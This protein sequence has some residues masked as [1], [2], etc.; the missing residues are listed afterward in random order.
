MY[1]NAI[2]HSVVR[3]YALRYVTYVRF[4]RD[5]R[6]NQFQHAV[7]NRRIYLDKPRE[8]FFFFYI[9]TQRNRKIVI[10]IHLKIRNN[11]RQKYIVTHRS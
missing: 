4:T 11:S 2:R 3:M 7:F 5:N 6:K 10:I 8:V 9:P 1:I